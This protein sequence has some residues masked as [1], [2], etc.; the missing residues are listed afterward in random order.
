MEIMP[1]PLESSTEEKSSISDSQW[2]EILKRILIISPLALPGCGTLTAQMEKDSMQDILS[3]SQE[4]PLRKEGGKE[5]LETNPYVYVSEE[6][7][8]E[9]FPALYDMIEASKNG[10]P[11]EKEE[12]EGKKLFPPSYARDDVLEKKIRDI[13]RKGLEEWSWAMA[14]G[15][16]AR[17]RPI[18]LAHG[19][20]I[21]GRAFPKGF[22]PEDQQF[23]DFHLWHEHTALSSFVSGG[24]MSSEKVMEIKEEYEKNP[25]AYSRL[26]H[27][28]SAIDFESMA[29]VMK[30]EGYRF[31]V[32]SSAGF[33]E[34]S[35]VE[36]PEKSAMNR[37][38]EEGGEDFVE[39]LNADLKKEKDV[40]NARATKMMILSM[41]GEKVSQGEF[42]AGINED[43]DGMAR[44]WLHHYE[45][46]A[47][48][49]EE[50]NSI[51]EYW[52]DWKTFSK[53]QARLSNGRI[54]L[55][56]GGALKALDSWKE[57]KIAARKLGYRIRFKDWDK[58]GK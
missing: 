51:Q 27:P 1:K 18:V 35:V 21:Q 20:G 53:A 3:V 48:T 8:Q 6:E 42:D 47:K 44:V 36:T 54:P 17:W 4:M 38:L 50:K 45:G 30:G 11:A 39:A 12:M 7:V 16:D 46:H 15:K 19:T 33:Y 34:F 56:I 43:I 26:A 41:K 31:F 57:Y 58:D 5:S 22:S 28:P 55:E 13:S 40:A 14:L 52:L 23:R 2:K 24:G 9:K 29:E 49:Q 10:I 25:D 32:S 37:I